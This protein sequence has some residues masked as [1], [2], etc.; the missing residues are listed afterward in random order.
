MLYERC[1]NGLSLMIKAN[2]LV[3]FDHGTIRNCHIYYLSKSFHVCK[4][5]VKPTA[6]NSNEGL[7][8]TSSVYW[9]KHIY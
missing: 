6:Q 1:G 5:S 3:L 8:Q 4:D 2:N 9:K 7:F